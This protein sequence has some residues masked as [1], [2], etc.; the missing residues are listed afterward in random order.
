MALRLIEGFESYGANGTTGSTL[1][2]ALKAKYGNVVTTYLSPDC[3]L[4][5][6]WGS[7]LGLEMGYETS[8]NYIQATFDAQT[9]WLVGLAIKTAPTLA[10]GTLI[11]LSSGSD[12]DFI[13]LV[14]SSSGLVYIFNQAASTNYYGT[15]V[16]RPST[17]YYLEFKAFIDGSTGTL[18]L[19]INGDSDISESSLDTLYTTSTNA[20][21]VTLELRL[22][23][24]TIIDDLYIADGTAGV[25]TFIGPYK[26]ETIRPDADDTVAWDRSAGGDNYALINSVGINES[27]Y[28]EGD[29]ITE[30][31]LY[32]F[33]NL[34]VITGDIAGIQITTGGLL[35]AAG[36]RQL[37]DRVLSDADNSNGAV[38]LASETGELNYRVI[39]QDPNT[40]ANWAVAAVD[41]VKAGVVV[42]D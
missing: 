22:G 7:G 5:D 31:D 27:S 9:T 38:V 42:G 29:T 8:N 12:A 40:A 6:G 41:A 2:D 16:L 20:S 24:G 1:E 39:E 14:L 34:S 32:T 11:S 13:R 35:T 26:V 37:N 25:N 17:W 15:R 23:E 19:N 18:D 30:S 3:L 10:S 36:T 28:V 4:N 33:G 21:R